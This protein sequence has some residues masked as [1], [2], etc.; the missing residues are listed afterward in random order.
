MKGSWGGGGM[1]LRCTS[2]GVR[3]GSCQV[4][5]AVVNFVVGNF[6]GAPGFCVVNSADTPRNVVVCRV[7]RA[8]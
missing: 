4:E 8:L 3:W 1:L 2:G 6:A 7:L 5:F